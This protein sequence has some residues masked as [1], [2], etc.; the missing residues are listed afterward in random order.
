MINHCNFICPFL[1]TDLN[2]DVH[3]LGM[4]VG[5]MT[6]YLIKKKYCRIENFEHNLFIY[7][8][9]FYTIHRSTLLSM[10]MTWRNPD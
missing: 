9:K 8:K 10:P 3:T 2:R 1:D 5:G 7:D 6:F 4:L